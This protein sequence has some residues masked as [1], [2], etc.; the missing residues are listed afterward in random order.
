MSERVSDA[1]VGDPKKVNCETQEDVSA[2]RESE[3]RQVEILP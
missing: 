1:R 3:S 2:R